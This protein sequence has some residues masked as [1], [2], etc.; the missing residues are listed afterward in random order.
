MYGPV[1]LIF[2]AGSWWGKPSKEFL[3]LLMQI[4]LWFR[5]TKQTKHLELGGEGKKKRQFPNYVQPA[6]KTQLL[7]FKQTWLESARRNTI[8]SVEGNK[9]SN[10]R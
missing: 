9:E 7:L 5:K 6:T 8:C 4:C 10:S 3:V 1:S 2:R